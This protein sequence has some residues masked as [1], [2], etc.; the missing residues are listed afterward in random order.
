MINPTLVLYVKDTK[1]LLF[2]MKCID[3]FYILYLLILNIKYIKILNSVKF[4]LFFQFTNA[5]NGFLTGKFV[6]Y[7]SVLYS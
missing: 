5:Y 4:K 2:L 1:L 7:S 6:L 3:N